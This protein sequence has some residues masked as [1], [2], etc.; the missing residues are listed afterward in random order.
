V[1][2]CKEDMETNRKVDSSPETITISRDPT[3]RTVEEDKAEIEEVVTTEAAVKVIITK[4]EIKD[5]ARTSGKITED[6]PRTT[7]PS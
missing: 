2:A 3:N 7:H 6:L 1:V 5:P 4:T